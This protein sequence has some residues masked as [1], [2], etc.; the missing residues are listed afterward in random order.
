[1]PPR[2]QSSLFHVPELHL[3]IPLPLLHTKIHDILNNAVSKLFSN[4]AH[5]LEYPFNFA[6]R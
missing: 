3:L 6:P 1:M 2:M 5:I 4:T